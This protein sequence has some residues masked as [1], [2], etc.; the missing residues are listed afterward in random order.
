M[1]ESYVQELLTGYLL[2]SAAMETALALLLAR[3]AVAA[4]RKA[5]SLQRSTVRAIAR[6]SRSSA[7][8]RT[9]SK[10]EVRWR[11]A[12]APRSRV[13]SPRRRRASAASRAAPTSEASAP[14][15]R[16]AT[17]RQVELRHRGAGGGRSRFLTHCK[18]RVA[19]ITSVVL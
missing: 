16:R 11:R 8:T 19:I 12:R 2:R 9:R 1:R 4:A 17:C 6:N 15:A 13:T 10:G 7:S 14:A 18:A 5:A 3:T